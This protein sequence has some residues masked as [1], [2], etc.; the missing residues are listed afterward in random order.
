VIFEPAGLTGA[1]IIDLEPRGDE[2]GFIA[3]QFCAAEFAA[4]G[5][6]TG[7]EQANVSRSAMAGTMRGLHY[8]NAPHAES[9]LV[10]CVRGAL[11]D[12]LVD[13]RPD[14]PTFRKWVGFELS[15]ENMRQ[16]YVP[17]GCAHGFLTLTDDVE[18]L[19][20]NSAAYAPQAEG[21]LRY[22]DPGIGIEWPG[23]IRVISDKDRSW[24][25]FVG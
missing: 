25:D 15:A 6:R 22:D 3:R 5:L 17:P 11:F 2:R 13:L 10:R 16:I 19:Y 24:P 23:E 14:S 9:K 12:V 20:L 7:V 21:G 8:Q 1:Y 4:H 18:A